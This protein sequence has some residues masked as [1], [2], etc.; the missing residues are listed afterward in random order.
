MA[1]NNVV[2]IYSDGGARGNP[3]PAA[4]AFVVIKNGRVIHHQTKYLST[5]TNNFAEYMAVLMALAWLDQNI[6]EIE[7]EEV[8]YFIDSELVAKQLS[9]IY[10]VKSKKLKQLVER[11]KAIEKKIDSD[12]NYKLVPRSKNK[13][14]DHLVNKT[15]DENV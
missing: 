13:L 12:I 9:G 3:G 14:A 10:K 15:L 6:K 1:F 8:E 5:T 4:A 2:K 7:A 11:I